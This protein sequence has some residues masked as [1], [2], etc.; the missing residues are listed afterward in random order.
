V[1]DDVIIV[2]AARRHIGR[3]AHPEGDLR[4]LFVCGA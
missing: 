1:D 4:R 2:A 3:A